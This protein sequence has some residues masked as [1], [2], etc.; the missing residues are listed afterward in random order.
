M[1]LPFLRDIDM[2]KA[3]NCD[4]IGAASRDYKRISPQ[5][6]RRSFSPSHQ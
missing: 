3:M 6:D 2:I 4:E 5:K 1:N